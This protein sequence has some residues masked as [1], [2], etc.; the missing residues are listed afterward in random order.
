MSTDDY[1]TVTEI[2]GD[3]VS[4]EQ[5]QRL[6][7]RYY[8]AAEFCAGKKVVEAACGSGQGVGLL[9]GVCE[10]FEAG[11]FSEPVLAVARRHYGDRA[12]LNQFDAQQMPFEDASKE[13][14]ILFEAI[15]Y[16]PDAEKFVQECRRVLRPGGMVLIATANKDLYDFNPS[17]KSHKYYGVPEL[18]RLFAGHGF[19]T[20]FYGGTPLTEVSGMQKL[21]R[22]I[23]K[24]AVEFNLIPKTMAAKKLLKTLV[25]GKLVSMPPEIA[26]DTAPYQKPVPI[27]ADAPDQRHK[28]IFCVAALDA[29][30][31]AGQA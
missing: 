18:N 2:A 4:H 13:V 23:K 12:V 29:Q 25:F 19:Q 26:H 28:V 31:E 22:P 7:N 5:V 10:H 14:I 11:D 3:E 1:T 20:S 24:L 6:C 15:Y 8:W 17:P 16:L 30:G 9:S 27:P 21:L